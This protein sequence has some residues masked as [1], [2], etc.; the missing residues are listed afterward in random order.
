M[1]DLRGDLVDDRPR[2]AGGGKQPLPRSCLVAL[3]RLA[4]RRQIRCRG[5]ALWRGHCQRAHVS[6]RRERPDRGHAVDGELDVAAE[7]A[8]DDFGG[9]AERNVRHLGVGRE[10]EHHR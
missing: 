1:S 10:L 3:E 2:R 9:A 5:A 4:D 6:R 8:V 7:H